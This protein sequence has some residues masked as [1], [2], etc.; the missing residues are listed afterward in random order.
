M[1]K[2][3]LCFHKNTKTGMFPCIFINNQS[4]RGST[5]MLYTLGY[6]VSIYF[7]LA[8]GKSLAAHKDSRVERGNQISRNKE[9][10]E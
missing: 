9:E 4:I 5:L 3:I 6:K 8:N 7:S 2:G 1:E 10:K